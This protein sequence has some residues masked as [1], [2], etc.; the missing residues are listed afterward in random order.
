MAEPTIVDTNTNTAPPA[1]PVEQVASSKPSKQ[2]SSSDDDSHRVSTKTHLFWML[3]FVV[4]QAAALAIITT[5]WPTADAVANECFGNAVGR[6]CSL[7]RTQQTAEIFAIIGELLGGIA[8]AIV[9]ADAGAKNGYFP[10]GL[11]ASEFMLKL[12]VYLW[13][14]AAVS[15]FITITVWPGKFP[16]LSNADQ[17]FPYNDWLGLQVTASVLSFVCAIAFAKDIRPFITPALL[18][19]SV[20]LEV[21][22]LSITDWTMNNDVKKICREQGGYKCKEARAQITSESFGASAAII[23]GFGFFLSFLSALASAEILP[24]AFEICRFRVIPALFCIITTLFGFTASVVWSSVVYHDSRN[25]D[26]FVA[27]YQQKVWLALQIASTV[28]AMGAGFFCINFNHWK[29]YLVPL[30]VLAF[31]AVQVSAVT[32]DWWPS[33]G[34][35]RHKYCKGS[36]SS[37]ICVTARSAVTSEAFGAAA[38]IVG[39]FTFFAAFINSLAKDEVTSF[40]NMSPVVLIMCIVTLCLSA[41]SAIVYPAVVTHYNFNDTDIAA[42]TYPQSWL[43]LQLSA[44]S[45]AYAA[46]FVFIPMRNHR[47]FW[48]AALLSGFVAVQLAALIYIDWP[49]P[50][51]VTDHECHDK[52]STTC[53][54]AR[55]MQGSEVLAICSIVAGGVSWFLSFVNAI[56]A[57]REE[58]AEQSKVAGIMGVIFSII[59][60]FCALISSVVWPGVYNQH[61]VTPNSHFIDDNTRYTWMQ[62][63]VTATAAAG[64][65]IFLHMPYKNYRR[66]LVTASLVVFFALQAGALSFLANDW[67]KAKDVTTYCNHFHIHGEFNN[68]C[69]NQRVL[70]STETFGIIAAILGGSGMIYTAFSSCLSMMRMLSVVLCIATSASSLLA[71]VIMACFTPAST[72]QSSTFMQLQAVATVFAFLSVPFALLNAKSEAWLQPDEAANDTEKN[73]AMH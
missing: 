30:C 52:E 24:K 45:I 25:P 63:Q 50:K 22:L 66:Y 2:Q 58:K 10:E 35:I 41:V 18:C 70:Q 13:S 46:C 64:L 69:V 73:V 61:P 5:A 34:D 20:V 53:R 44:V 59:G 57:N 9:A 19:A 21:T 6:K 54:N 68:V 38:A 15:T 72:F 23:G 60:A 33:N 71:S 47:T 3:A 11:K 32:M 28:L 65:S 55:A 8:L 31:V 1:Q 40:G 36:W 43:K 37:P 49:K 42:V 16:A 62:L 14:A 12:P 67:P 4:M 27:D 26:A 29:K 39:G 7:M 51:H 48:N 17:V 56:M